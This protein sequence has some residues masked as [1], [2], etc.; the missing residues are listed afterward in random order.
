MIKRGKPVDGAV[1]VTFSLPGE[2]AP[3]S[4]VGDF[5]DWDPLAN[6]LRRRSNGT[7]SVSLT[8]PTATTYAF[9]YLGEAHGFFDDETAEEIVDNGYGGTHGVLVT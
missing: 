1:K 4:V 3:V 6:P 7:C 9:R 5:N 8:L 2:L